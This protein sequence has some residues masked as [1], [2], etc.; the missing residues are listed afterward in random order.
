MGDLVSRSILDGL[1]YDLRRSGRTPLKLQNL[2]IGLLNVKILGFFGIVV[3]VVIV[4]VVVDKVVSLFQVNL[5][6]DPFE[7][8][9]SCRLLEGVLDALNFCSFVS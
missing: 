2:R 9:D 3:V 5:L 1:S 8:R 6:Q 4:L 7:V